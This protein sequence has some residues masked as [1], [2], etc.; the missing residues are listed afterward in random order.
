LN[1]IHRIFFQL[2]FLMPHYCLLP[3]CHYLLTLLFNCSSSFIIVGI[4][5]V[6]FCCS[7]SIGHFL[8]KMPRQL[9]FLLR[10]FRFGNIWY[11][12]IWDVF[13]RPWPNNNHSD[14]KA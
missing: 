2:V 11:V 3:F 1:V 6:C 5:Q 12:N 14:L 10:M 13:S 4:V 9:K 8:T 7:P